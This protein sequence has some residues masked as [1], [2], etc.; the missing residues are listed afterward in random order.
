MFINKINYTIF[1]Y[2][3]Y[4]PFFFLCT[5]CDLNA[6]K[7][8]LL[9]QNDELNVFVISSSHDKKKLKSYPFLIPGHF[10]VS[11]TYPDI[12]LQPSER[13][14]VLTCSWQSGIFSRGW[15]FSSPLRKKIVV[16]YS[17]GLYNNILSLKLY[18]THSTLTPHK[19]FVNTPLPWHRKQL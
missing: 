4:L 10:K 19:W 3:Y 5:L 2:V 17:K 6:L 9:F 13:L 7:I 12:N 16:G 15:E 11:R 18:Y 14:Q 1:I 8:R